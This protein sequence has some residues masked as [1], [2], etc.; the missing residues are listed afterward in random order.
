MTN[1]VVED[2]SDVKKKITFEVPPEKY[3]EV[4][5]N[6][7]KD[8]KKEVQLKGFRKGKV[9]MNILRAYF[10][11]QVHA[12]VSRKL[13]DETFKP[14]LDEH[15][16]MP[17][18]VIKIEPQEIEEEGPFTYVAEIEVP[19]PLDVE[20]YKGLNLTK[21]V[22]EVTEEDIRKRLEEVQERNAKLAPV[23]EARPLR[24]GDHAI[25]NIEA[26]VDGEKEQALSVTDYS[27]EIG[28]DF[29]LPDF[30][31]HFVGLTIGQPAEIAWTA[32]ED[33]SISRLADKEITFKIEPL[34]A[35][36][37]VLPTLDDDFAKDLGNFDTLDAL[38]AEIREDI[39]KTNEDRTKK[40]LEKQIIDAL[41]AA[42]D[43]EPPETMVEN[44]IDAKVYQTR[45][46]FQSMGIDPRRYPEP[47]FEERK[48]YRPDAERAVKSWLL[49]RAIGE[50]EGLEVTDDDIQAG[51]AERA[52]AMGLSAEYLRE[53]MEEGDVLDDFR[54]SLLQEKVLAMIRDN[55]NITEEDSPPPSDDAEDEMTETTSEK[56]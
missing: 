24:E 52:E 42:N 56:E 12:D 40:N 13:I 53:E 43:F 47:D 55:A 49:L 50:K 20:G 37:R 46:M 15:N 23:D 38:K 21:Y 51:L 32:P 31:E 19:P 10:K 35:K 36:E 44:Q 2:L 8:L 26:F 27:V 18:S 54:S 14:A 39:R 22:Q 30:D 4:S 33:F 34:E 17:V 45:R 5:D 9:P 3:A 16:I 41:I 1:V 25:V 7:F 48:I 29:Y 28:R 6:Q 11:D